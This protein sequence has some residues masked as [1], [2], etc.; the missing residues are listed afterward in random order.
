MNP[1]ITCNSTH[2]AI[3]LG[4]NA[5]TIM[6]AALSP[7][8]MNYSE[9]LSTLRY[10][11]RAKQIKNKAIINEDP[12][13]KLIRQLKEELD[14]LKKAMTSSLSSSPSEENNAERPADI[15]KTPAEAKQKEEE[16][17]RIREQ[18]E[19]NQKL[20]EESQKSWNDRLRE[21]EELAKQREEQ[22][23]AIGLVS[24]TTMD[25]QAKA[26]KEPYLLNL[27]EDLLMSEKLFYFL[28]LGKTHIGREANNKGEEGDT[29][30]IVL[31]GLGILARHCHI[32]RKMVQSKSGVDQDSISIS[33]VPESGAKVFLN[34]KQVL[35]N[36]K[37]PVLVNHCDRLVFG[38]NSIFRL[39]IPSLRE[40][41]DVAWKSSE[42]QY[43][44][45]FAMKELNSAQ[46][47]MWSKSSGEAEAEA[48]R[49][50]MAE[51]LREMEARIAQEQDLAQ[52]TIATQRQEWEAQARA[53]QVEMDEKEQALRKQIADDSAPASER[54]G[55]EEALAT[56]LADQ[57]A[58]LAEDLA[59][60][61]L[62][63][64]E[65]QDA[66]LAK[67]SELESSLQQQIKE[68][69]VL[70]SRKERER[71][72]RVLLDEALLYEISL[73]NEANSISEELTK[74]VGFAL[75]LVPGAPN[76]KILS[77]PE[78]DALAITD[79]IVGELRIQVCEKFES[80]KPDHEF[81]PYSFIKYSFIKYSFTNSFTY[82]HY[83]IFIHYSNIHYSNNQSYS[84]IHV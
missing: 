68:T 31:G 65:K 43:D 48:E 82:I 12:N 13:Q 2:D 28:P 42:G 3:N 37:D 10:A 76:T 33:L 23:R 5:K 73:V 70:A 60:A 16:L 21:T 78:N 32:E 53:L 56:A 80:V 49:E 26:L 6:I 35:E 18:L 44:W 38:N 59:K 29:Q 45:Q 17:A 11:D 75:K 84:L 66:L 55:A 36:P 8:A 41:D 72:E 24:S 27:H 4:G 63:Y 20:L 81:I 74:H 67:Q 46:A 34:G 57:E 14:E 83:S 52:A 54:Q 40:L 61:E 9:T 77:N 58:K 39:V 30:D 79:S 71:T 62:E 64:Q 19:M 1:V 7:A 47:H 25:V 69:K 15:T 22:L 51:R 50:A